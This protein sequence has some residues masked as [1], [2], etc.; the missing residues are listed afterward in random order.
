MPRRDSL[1]KPRLLKCQAQKQ[2]RNLW[3]DQ[4]R[5]LLSRTTENENQTETGNSNSSAPVPVVSENE[6]QQREAN[7]ALQRGQSERVAF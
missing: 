3:L 1:L 5:A 2:S 6:Q 4:F 7:E